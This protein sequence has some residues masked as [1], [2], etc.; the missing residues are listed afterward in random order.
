MDQADT[1]NYAG[2]AIADS[3]CSCDKC[4]GACRF[5][6]GLMMAEEA[7]GLVRRGYG[8]QLMLEW[9]DDDGGPYAL[10]NIKFLRTVEGRPRR[11]YFLCPAI[12]GREGA[13]APD[14]Y[15]NHVA[16]RI[17]VTG[18]GKG[19]CTFFDGGLCTV[20][21]SGFKP[22]ECRYAFGCRTDINAR[23]WRTWVHQGVALSWDRREA[24]SLVDSW[25]AQSNVAIEPI[26]SA[27]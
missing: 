4:A 23:A 11:F 19:A 1:P 14:T 13:S 21:D 16:F 9:W 20:H 12:Q 27:P 15:N 22:A 2:G 10:K 7:A 18:R 17:L 3:G 6:P 5:A 24:Q 26:S 25:C 8:H